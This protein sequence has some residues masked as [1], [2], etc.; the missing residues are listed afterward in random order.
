MIIEKN[1]NYKS[2]SNLKKQM[3]ELLC[4]S[5][6][7]KISYFYTSY[8]EVHNSYGR[9][10]IN[11]NKKEMAA[12]SWVEMYKK[13]SD[14]YKALSNNEDTTYEELERD[15]WIPECILCE[16]D[17]INSVTQYLNINVANALKSDNYIL[18]VFAY[19]DRRVGKRTLLKI[20]EDALLLPDW[21]KQFYLLRCE[22]D[23]VNIKLNKTLEAHEIYKSLF[24]Y[25]SNIYDEIKIDDLG[26]LL[27]DMRLLSDGESSDP[28]IYEDWKRLCITN[29]IDESD[30]LN[31]C[32]EFL[33]QYSNRINS[34]GLLS[35]INEIDNDE[36][37][38]YIIK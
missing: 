29:S 38:N 30:V 8:H 16:G 12:F 13:D 9:A 31:I 19:M 35:L 17:F 24:K 22:A 14:Y 34:K 3:N 7:D 2:W 32:V 15:K 18:R 37:L 28:A 1:S 36:L 23:K 20:K 6:K 27:G 5:L 4:D 26:C 21:V 10:T 33:T 11:Y 25:L